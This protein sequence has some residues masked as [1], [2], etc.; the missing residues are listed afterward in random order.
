MNNALK[1]VIFLTIG[2]IAGSLVTKFVV[3]KKSEIEKEEEINSVRKYYKENY[4]KPKTDEDD[5]HFDEYAKDTAYIRS[6]I[7]KELND[8]FNKDGVLTINEVLDEFIKDQQKK[9]VDDKP[10]SILDYPSN[11]KEELIDYSGIK[12]IEDE[13]EDEEE[14][15][16]SEEFQ[17]LNLTKSKWDDIY[18]IDTTDFDLDT[19]YD[20]VLLYYY[21]EDG[22]VANDDDDIVED[23]QDLIGTKFVNHFDEYVKDTAYIRNDDLRTDYEI[24]RCEESYHVGT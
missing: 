22:I 13:V 9:T 10:I 8:Q 14:S 16:E 2:A 21:T 24:V 23:H 17:P 18:D 15:E 12:K 1:N 3:L 6:E 4:T 19:D 11:V 5:N 20:K 7:M